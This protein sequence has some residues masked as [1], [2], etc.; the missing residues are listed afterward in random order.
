MKVS[1]II[2]GCALWL[3]MAATGYAIQECKGGDRAARGI[4]CVVDGDTLWVNGEKLRMLEIDA[5]ETYG[6]ACGRERRMG[7]AAKAR[8]IALMDRGY[9]IEYSGEKDRTADHRQ[10]VR[11]ILNDGRDAGEVLL[12]ERLAQPWPNKGNIWC[13]R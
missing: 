10:L 3:S 6:A 8:L 1:T 11:V 5:P 7:E 4:T 9:R 12:R 13:D 2:A